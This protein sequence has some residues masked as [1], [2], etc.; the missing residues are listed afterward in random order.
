MGVHD[1]S[2]HRTR[3]LLDE[4]KAPSAGGVCAGA[5]NAKYEVKKR[6]RYG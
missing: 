3:H 2:F 4:A 5:R 6:A 1:Y